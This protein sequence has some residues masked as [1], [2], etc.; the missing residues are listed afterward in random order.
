GAEPAVRP[1]AMVGEGAR[2]AG[3]DWV[4]LGVGEG[5]VA[6]LWNGM[7]QAASVRASTTEARPGALTVAGL[8]NAAIFRHRRRPLTP[9]ATGQE[10]AEQDH[11]HAH[12]DRNGE[13]LAQQ[14]GA[15]EH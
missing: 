14:G 15:P 9:R 10:H 7:L 6:A 12:Q 13:R 2:V 11:D 3:A 5:V 1:W 4:G 8:G